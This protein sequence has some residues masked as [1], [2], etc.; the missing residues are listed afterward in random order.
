MLYLLLVSRLKY[1]ENSFF[2]T[3]G[4]IFNE[5]LAKFM[6]EKKRAVKK[7]TIQ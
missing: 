6:P 5:V 3:I 4:K 7:G 1:V 2:H